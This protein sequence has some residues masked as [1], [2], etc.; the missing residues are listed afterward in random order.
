MEGPGPAVGKRFEDADR[1]RVSVFRNTHVKLC[2]AHVHAGHIEI[3]LLQ[4]FH[5]WSPDTSSPAFSFHE[6]PFTA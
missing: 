1:F 5:F 6:S 3:D 2:G 4:A